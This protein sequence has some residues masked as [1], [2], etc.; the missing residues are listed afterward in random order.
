MTEL[1][2]GGNSEFGVK[3]RCEDIEGSHTKDTKGDNQHTNHCQHLSDPRAPHAAAS[4]GHRSDLHLTVVPTTVVAIHLINA[5]SV[6]HNMY[7][8][9]CGSAENVAHRGVLFLAMA[10]PSYPFFYQETTG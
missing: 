9:A 2:V 10:R 5:I 8:E 7:L 1:D 4:S 6:P 3:S